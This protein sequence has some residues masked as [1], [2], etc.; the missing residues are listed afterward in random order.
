M[1]TSSTLYTQPFGSGGGRDSE[2]LCDDVSEFEPVVIGWRNLNGILTVLVESV[3]EAT[4]QRRGL[5][6]TEV[7]SRHAV[8]WNGGPHWES[9]GKVESG[10]WDNGGMAVAVLVLFSTPSALSEIMWGGRDIGTS[11]LEMWCWRRS[12][13]SRCRSS[14]CSRFQARACL[15]PSPFGR[16]EQKSKHFAGLVSNSLAVRGEGHRG[17]DPELSEHSSDVR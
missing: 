12:S 5:R 3:D 15:T 16:G 4:C 8:G 11:P 2:T 9:R 1:L 7:K 14:N 6:T 10:V 13:H 17:V